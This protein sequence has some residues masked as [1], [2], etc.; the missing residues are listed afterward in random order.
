M[1][2]N[3]LSAGTE[4]G[5][6]RVS[7]TVTWEDC[8]RPRRLIY[9]ETDTGFVN[10]MSPNPNAFLLAGIMPAMHKRE[11]RI[12]VEGKICPQL[13]NGLITG[14]LQLQ[15][16]YGKKALR[17]V[18]IEATRGFAPASPRPSQRTGMFLSGGV[19]S[20]ATLRC[21]RLDFPRGH[22]GSVA[23]GIIVHGF[24]VGGPGAVEYRRDHFKWLVESLSTLADQAGL[25]LIPVHTN[26]RE[27]EDE[28]VFFAVESCGAALAATAHQ[29]SERTSTVL[30]ASSASILDRG[31]VACHPLLDPS[32][33]SSSE[34]RMCYDGARLERLEKVRL[35][36]DWPAAMQAVSVCNNPFLPEGVAN[37]GHCAKCLLTMAELLVCGKLRDGMAFPSSVLSPEMLG[38]LLPEPPDYQRLTPKKAL[39][40]SAHVIN[41]SDIHFWRELIVPLR[42]VGRFELAALLEVKIKAHESHRKRRRGS[43]WKAAVKRFDANYFGG[44]LVRLKRVTNT[45]R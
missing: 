4:D 45:K 40:T 8:D 6:A 22:P 9:I 5:V 32:Y 31:P 3:N 35:I 37:C 39:E 33:A 2:I 28:G 11:R 1:K 43:H 20:L 23:D 24:D 41:D 30:V 38:A 7:A 13:R 34:M 10:D 12:R 19:D 17:P 18:Q 29:F 36:A 16:L 27:L 14:M 21:N 15:R 44:A 26:L 42:S 25:V